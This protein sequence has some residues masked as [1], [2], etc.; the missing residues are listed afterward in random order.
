M[1]DRMD[2]IQPGAMPWLHRYVGNPILSGTLNFFF[3]TGVRD[4]HCGMRARAPRRAAAAGPAR[5]RHGVRLRDGRARRQGEAGHP[6]VP[7]RV[8]PAR[9]RVRSSRPGATAGA[10]CASC[11]STARRTCSS[12]RPRSC[13][14][15]GALIMLT[16][17]TQLEIFGREWDVHTMIAGSLL[18]IVGTQIDRP[19]PLRARLRHVL[20]RLP[21]T[22][23]ST[24]CARASGSST[25]SRSAARSRS[26]A[27]SVAAG[28][29]ASVDRSRLR[30]AERGPPRR[31][32]PRR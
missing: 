27:S 4:A 2:Q 29:R 11:S 32:S 22:R 18:V 14:S 16:V 17:L 7:D 20:P 15:L 8:P 28:R 24:A 12:S 5:D 21:R 6:P 23:G 26:S 31:S 13:S 9:R 1:G 19:R 10:T 3:R 25:A 30:R